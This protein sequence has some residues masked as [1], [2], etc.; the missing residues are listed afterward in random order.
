MTKVATMPKYGQNFYNLLPNQK[1]N[2]LDMD[3]QGLKV[4]KVYI[5][6]D[7]GFTL[8]YFTA[9]SDLVKLLCLC[10]TNSQ[11]SIY[12]TIGPSG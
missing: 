12:W 8:T 10:Q 6:D 1:F 7:S 2:D 9:R 4:Y 11:V 3:H 5:N